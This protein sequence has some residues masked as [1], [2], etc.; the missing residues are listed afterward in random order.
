MLA[1]RIG[2]NDIHKII[3]NV[4]END[5]LKQELYDWAMGEDNKTGYQAAWILTHFSSQD[6]KWL[7]TKQNELIDAVLVCQ[8]GGRRRILL[9]LLYKQPLPEHPRVDFLDFC[10]E[11]MASPKELPG[12]QSLCMKIAYQLCRSIPELMNELKITLEMMQVDA[13]PAI[14]TTR[15]NIFKAMQKGRR[16][17]KL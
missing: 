16:L 11:R 2:M 7:Y 14:R 10:L 15:K 12:V 9:G 4:R 13:C 6:N 1:G 17:Q 5:Q 3:H 8:H